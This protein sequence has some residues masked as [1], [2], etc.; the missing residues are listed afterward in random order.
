MC[1]GDWIGEDCGT[2]LIAQPV[3]LP[4]RRPT[5]WAGRAAAA[6]AWY[7]GTRGLERR[8]VELHGE[9]RCRPETAYR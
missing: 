7:N 2:D 4:A 5:R 8:L 1:R 3:Y 9:G 6:A